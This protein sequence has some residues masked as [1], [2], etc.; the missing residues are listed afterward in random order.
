M[1]R[2]RFLPECQTADA[3]R[4]HE[5][6][7]GMSNTNKF[8]TAIPGICGYCGKSGGEF[9]RATYLVGAPEGGVPVHR[10]C[11]A[12]FFDSITIHEPFSEDAIL[13]RRL[14]R[15]GWR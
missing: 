6:G 4:S 13:L 3:L 5:R 8:P 2:L 15:A 10:E 9:E 14:L 7:C 11:L 12:A 1:A